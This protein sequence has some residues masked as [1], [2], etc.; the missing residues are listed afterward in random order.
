MVQFLSQ[1]KRNAPLKLFPDNFRVRSAEEILANELI[2]ICPWKRFSERS[3]YSRRGSSNKDEGMLPLSWLDLRC[4]SRM[5]LR[6]LKAVTYTCSII[7]ARNTNILKE[8]FT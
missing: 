7:N 5:C 3:K 4:N 1:K 6:F 2:G 8:C